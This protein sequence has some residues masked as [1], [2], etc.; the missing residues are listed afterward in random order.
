MLAG[1]DS[2]GTVGRFFLGRR[3]AD[4]ANAVGRLSGPPTF[5]G[6]DLLESSA[7]PATFW[8]FQSIEWRLGTI[9]VQ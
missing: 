5:R 7:D 3:T 8:G 6:E 9:S 1:F 4:S 2:V